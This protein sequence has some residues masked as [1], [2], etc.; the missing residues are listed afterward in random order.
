MK[1]L[2]TGDNSFNQVM[3]LNA[4]LK[5]TL[6]VNSSPYNGGQITVIVNGIVQILASSY[7]IDQDANVT[8]MATP[9]LNYDFS[10]WN[11][12]F[13]TNTFSFNMGSNT[14][15][16]AYFTARVIPQI[17]VSPTTIPSGSSISWRFNGFT[18]GQSVGVSLIGGGGLNVTADALG[19]GSGSFVVTESV[20]GQYGIQATDSLGEYATA[21]FTV[22][23]TTPPPP[24]GPTFPA[25]G[26]I[27]DGNYWY[28]V[29]YSDGTIGWDDY[30]DVLHDSLPHPTIISGPY[31]SGA[32]G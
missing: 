22:T 9:N 23:V 10:N 21:F 20:A 24:S 27:G 17:T 8:V 25:P 7:S 19:S 6:T 2:Y 13:Y 28:W 26:T 31:A 5:Y 30:N 3:V 15:M 1:T 29:Q 11:N 32:T 16:T 14:T 18:P 4:P 12:M